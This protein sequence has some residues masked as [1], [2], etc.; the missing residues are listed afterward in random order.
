MSN[1]LSDVRQTPHALQLYGLYS[2]SVD[3]DEL[4][5]AMT[6]AS[7]AHLLVEKVH[8]KLTAMA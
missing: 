7:V 1:L 8:H 4:L 3:R 2:T 5:S 6:S